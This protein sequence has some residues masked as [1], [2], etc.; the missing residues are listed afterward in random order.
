MDADSDED[1][2]YASPWDLKEKS[3]RAAKR[4]RIDQKEQNLL[5]LDADPLVLNALQV[6]EQHTSSFTQVHCPVCQR[7]FAGAQVRL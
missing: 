6:D 3:Q 2:F 5:D 7:A 1:D 4:V